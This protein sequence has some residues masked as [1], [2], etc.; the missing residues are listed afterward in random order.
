VRT[1]LRAFGEAARHLIADRRL[2]LRVAGCNAAVF[3]ADGLTLAVCLAA[4]GQPFR[5]A[6]GFIALM[7]ASI[8]ATLGPIPMAL[9]SSG[10]SSVAMLTVLGVSLEAAVAAALLLRSLTLWLPLAPGLILIRTG[11]GAPGK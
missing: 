9:G 10:A 4:L 1:L 7:M 6:T 8:V 2:I 5:V 3:L 11:P